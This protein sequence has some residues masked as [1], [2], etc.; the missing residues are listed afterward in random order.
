MY[1][2]INHITFLATQKFY[3]KKVIRVGVGV[4]VLYVVAKEVGGG[5][6][7]KV[8]DYFSRHGR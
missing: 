5:V 8:V 7:N 2:L 6:V 3:R 1:H 4:R